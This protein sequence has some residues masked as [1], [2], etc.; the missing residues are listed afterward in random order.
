M[1]PRPPSRENPIR[2]AP[3]LAVDSQLSCVEDPPMT[4]SW[5]PY[6]WDEPRP[7]PPEALEALER[8]WQLRFPAEYKRLMSSCQGMT[9]QPAGFNVG[10]AETSLGVLLTLTEHERW[11]EY[12]ILRTYE[13]TRHYV[14]SRVYPFAQTPAG[15]LVCFDY[16]VAAEQPSII[17]ITV[18]GDIHLVAG[19]FT[20][21]LSKLHD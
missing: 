1:T 7:A 5:Q 11:P 12:S 2:L 8:Q 15:E 10:R 4:V 17:F 18:E 19:S 20:D 9:P 14:P 6:L 3:P 13:S 21:F 16:R